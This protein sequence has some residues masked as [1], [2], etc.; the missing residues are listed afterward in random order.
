MKICI[1]FRV[2][3]ATNFCHTQTDRHFP[4][5]VK[6]CSRYPK[7]CKSIKNWKSE[8]FPK[9]ILSF[10]NIEECK[11]ITFPLIP[12]PIYQRKTRFFLLVFDS[13][14]YGYVFAFFPSAIFQRKSSS[15]I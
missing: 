12:S 5:I 7:M 3:L 14:P 15:D 11:K 8:N 10:T 13:Q 1:S 4:E 6:T 9:P 2:P